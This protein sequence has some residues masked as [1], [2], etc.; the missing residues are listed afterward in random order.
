MVFN[1][2]KKFLLSLALM[3]GGG[4]PCPL[5]LAAARPSSCFLLFLSIRT[6]SSCDVGVADAADAVGVVDLTGGHAFFVLPGAAPVATPP[7]P[8][9]GVFAGMCGAPPPRGVLAGM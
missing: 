3:P 5:R 6:G 8:P 2:H 4:C 1:S 9:R 7:P